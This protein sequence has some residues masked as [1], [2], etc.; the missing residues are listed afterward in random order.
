MTKKDRKKKKKKKKK[1][2]VDNGIKR[3]KPHDKEVSFSLRDIQNT[4]P[5]ESEEEIMVLVHIEETN[6][7]PVIRILEVRV[8]VFFTSKKH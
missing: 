2:K 1:M 6:R 7:I 8:A 3:D 4:F 5:K